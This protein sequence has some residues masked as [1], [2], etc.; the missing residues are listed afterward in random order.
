[1]RYW[2]YNIYNPTFG[3]YNLIY[4]LGEQL[5]IHSPTLGVAFFCLWDAPTPGW[6]S[7]KKP[8]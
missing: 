1:M 5:M 6:D 3:G 8:G 7:S 4:N 2:G